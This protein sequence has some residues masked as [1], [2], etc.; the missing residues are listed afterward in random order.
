L[1]LVEID[2]HGAVSV[3]LA[4]GLTVQGLLMPLGSRG[5]RGGIVI[6][7]RL[8]VTH[9]GG[10]KDSRGRPRNVTR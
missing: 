2:G 9:G 4:G 10:T 6:Q 7:V 1:V 3:K 5:T 8:L